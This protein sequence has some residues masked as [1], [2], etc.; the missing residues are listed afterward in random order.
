MSESIHV[1]CPHCDKTNRLPASRAGQR[2]DCGA[3]GRPLFPGK[4]LEIGEARFDEYLRRTD[5]PVVVDFW[6]AWCGPCRMMAPQFE[7]AA[8]R[9]AGRVQFLK[10]DTD[11]NPALS[12]RYA[13]RSIP[14]IALFHGGREV[15]RSAG[16]MSAAQIEA[17]IGA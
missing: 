5:L 4:P 3:C 11:A 7:Q 6:A 14:T 10:V 17:W 8:Q 12:Q 1:V 15:R 2:P 13:I 9:L 16:A